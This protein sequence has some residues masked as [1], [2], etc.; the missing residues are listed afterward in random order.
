MRIVQDAVKMTDVKFARERKSAR[1]HQNATKN[2][3]SAPFW[4]RGSWESYS[5]PSDPWLDLG[6]GGYREGG[7]LSISDPKSWSLQIS[8][9]SL[10]RR[11]LFC[12]AYWLVSNSF[13][14]WQ[15]SNRA[16]MYWRILFYLSDFPLITTVNINSL[17][18]DSWRPL[19]GAYSELQLRGREK[20]SWKPRSSRPEGPRAGVGLPHQLEG[21]GERCIPQR[22]PVRSPGRQ[23][24]LPHLKYSGWLFAHCSRRLAVLA[25]GVG[26]I[27]YFLAPVASALLVSST[28]TLSLFRSRI[29][30]LPSCRCRSSRIRFR[31]CFMNMR[32]NWI[33][34]TFHSNERQAA[35]TWILDE[36]NMLQEIWLWRI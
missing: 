26:L 19:A 18:I 15:T 30:T 10:L 7:D 20:S 16:Q 34:T 23:A 2:R 8:S 35:Q 28:I 3:L 4:G 17:N 32:R 6:R 31:C 9:L 14:H 22:G 21:L 29:L 33:E 24:I 25:L 36:A 27:T 12:N 5:A 13:D 1:F 11:T